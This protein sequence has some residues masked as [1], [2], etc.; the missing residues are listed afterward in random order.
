[1]KN[2]QT[3]IETLKSLGDFEDPCGLAAEVQVETLMIELRQSALDNPNQSFRLS[4]EG[5]EQT[6][7]EILADL[8]NEQAAIDA[9]RQALD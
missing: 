8:D 9:L 5:P 2:H 4:E 1:M 3:A 6:I 7:V